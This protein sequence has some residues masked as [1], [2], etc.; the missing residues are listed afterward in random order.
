MK[1][2]VSRTIRIIPPGT[3]NRKSCN[4]IARHE[5]GFF[6]PVFE[7]ATGICGINSITQR[8]EPA[9]KHLLVL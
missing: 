6:A 7:F 1:E 2:P 4:F 8:V 5:S 3:V 9:N